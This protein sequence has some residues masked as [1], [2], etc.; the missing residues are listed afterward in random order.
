MSGALCLNC[1]ETIPFGVIADDDVGCEME[2]TECGKS[3]T[4]SVQI[5]NDGGD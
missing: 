1:G 3:G 4:I 5:C 2:C